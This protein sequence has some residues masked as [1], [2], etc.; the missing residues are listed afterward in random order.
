MSDGKCIP[1]GLGRMGKGRESG[2]ASQLC[3]KRGPRQPYAAYI[4][5]SATSA[6]FLNAGPKTRMWVQEVCLVGDPSIVMIRDGR[7]GHRRS[8]CRVSSWVGPLQF[9]P[10]DRLSNRGAEG[11]L[12]PSRIR[13]AL[14]LSTPVVPT[15]SAPQHIELSMAQC[16]TECPCMR[17]LQALSVDDPQA[18]RSWGSVKSNC[19]HHLPAA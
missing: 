18:S 4:P 15:C 14:E 5:L 3:R 2:I 12:W 1:G 10:G 16:T 6:V 9:S 17:H 8:Q 7:E 11:G 13:V 19:L